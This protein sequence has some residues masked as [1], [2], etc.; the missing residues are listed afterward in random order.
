MSKTK[1]ASAKK[2]GNTTDALGVS[3]AVAV[4]DTGALNVDG[5]TSVMSNAVAISAILVANLCL[6]AVESVAVAVSEI[7]SLTIN[8]AELASVIEAVS[9]TNSCT[10]SLAA[11]VSV[12]VAFSAINV[13]NNL[14]ALIASV[15]VAD[16]EMA[17]R[18]NRIPVIVSVAVAVSAILG[19]YV[20][21]GALIKSVAV[22]VSAIKTLIAPPGEVWNIQ[23]NEPL[24]VELAPAYQ[25]VARLYARTPVMVKKS[26]AGGVTTPTPE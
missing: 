23:P 21:P 1:T 7:C 14:A 6:A 20:L 12:A 11:F 16:S 8:L 4:S 2:F 22:D 19:L 9:A 10:V 25:V 3:V 24:L 15:A 18:N 13:L 26:M 5:A 17:A